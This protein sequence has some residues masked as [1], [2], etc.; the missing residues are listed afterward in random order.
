MGST[1]GSKQNLA[2]VGLCMFQVKRA[3]ESK[4][5]IGFMGRSKM[6]SDQ[7]SNLS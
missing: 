4:V 5:V 6:D 3:H 2:K 1:L 7:T